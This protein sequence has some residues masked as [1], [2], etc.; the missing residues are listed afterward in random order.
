MKV[1]I[2][3]GGADDLRRKDPAG[4]S[5]LAPLPGGSRGLHRG[6]DTGKRHPQRGLRF[7]GGGGGGRQKT[8]GTPVKPDDR[9]AAP[10]SFRGPRISLVTGDQ[11]KPTGRAMKSSVL[12][13]SS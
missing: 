1:A 7:H 4:P 13:I 8:A 6:E 2:G 12:M 9:N 11:P 10:G 5:G 3:K